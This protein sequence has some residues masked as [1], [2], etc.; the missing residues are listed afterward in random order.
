MNARP[1]TDAILHPTGNDYQPMVTRRA[2]QPG[3]ADER[4]LLHTVFVAVRQRCH[5]DGLALLVG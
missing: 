3:H 2:K 4:P 1:L 5:Q